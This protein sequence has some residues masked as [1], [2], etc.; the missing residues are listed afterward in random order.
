MYISSIIKHNKFVICAS[1]LHLHMSGNFLFL[2]LIKTADHHQNYC[3]V[4]LRKTPPQ[5]IQEKEQQQ[6]TQRIFEE[7]KRLEPKK[8]ILCPYKESI[9]RPSDSALRCS[10]TETFTV[11]EVYYEVHMTRV[12]HTTRISNVHSE[13]YRD[14]CV[15]IQKEICLFV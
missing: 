6:N 1:F 3:Y 2:C 11:S 10:T 15:Y 8:K 4:Y 13:I 7:T 5:N 12:L 14:R 9:L